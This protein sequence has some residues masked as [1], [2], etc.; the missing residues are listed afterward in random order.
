[1]I[2][3]RQAHVP[4]HLNSLSV[5]KTGVPLLNHALIEELMLE[6]SITSPKASIVHCEGMMTIC[7]QS[8]TDIG[9]RPSAVYGTFL[10]QHLLHKPAI[11]KN[12]GGGRAKLK[13]IDPAVLFRPFCEC[14]MSSF[15]RQLMEVADHR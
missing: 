4:Q 8:V 13:G 14:Q 12:D 3:R 5:H 11:R 2:F 1:M 7:D 10:I 6:L 15:G 9:V